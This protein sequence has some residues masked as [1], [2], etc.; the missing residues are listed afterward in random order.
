[1]ERLSAKGHD[2]RVI[3]FEI[4]WRLREP[5]SRISRRTVFEH[6]RK[7]THNGDV[8]VIRPPIIRVGLIDYLSLLFTHTIEI[9][10]QLDEFKP[11]VIVGFGIL[12]SYIALKLAKKRN[13][14]FL[15]YVIDELH[16]L[17]PQPLLQNIAK[18]IE[19]HNLEV[20]DLVMSINEEL[21]DYT[22]EMGAERLKTAVLEAGVD[23]QKFDAISPQ[24]RQRARNE[25]GFQESDIILF[26]MGWLY[27][28]SGITEVVL[29]MSKEEWRNSPLKLLIVG[30]GDAWDEINRLIADNNLRE[31]VV[32]EK[33]RPYSQIAA[34]TA[35]SDICILPAHKNKIMMNIVP[36]KMYEYMAAKKPV[37]ATRLPG[38]V[39]QFGST[40]GV[41]YINDPQEVLSMAFELSKD[42]KIAKEGS[43]A[44][45]FVEKNDWKIL[46]E[47]FEIYLKELVQGTKGIR[48][49]D[50]WWSS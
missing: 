11:H 6:V 5:S 14:P 25:F 2:I 17:V 44:R 8:T 38:L 37:I 33:W 47:S 42:G 29:E 9:R 45:V 27:N 23:L 13:I 10:R 32:I 19:I 1:M 12:N 35:S 16:R 41:T 31:K 3:D 4:L 34:L 26:F 7:A 22:V 48:N 49:S 21:R 39:R 50:C 28:F 18:K 43:K 36:I 20:A 46:T 30:S 24:D 15:Y 40:N